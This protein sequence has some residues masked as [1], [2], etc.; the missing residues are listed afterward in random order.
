MS[1][2]DDYEQE[3]SFLSAGNNGAS[4]KAWER[5]F[6]IPQED[7]QEQEESYVPAMVLEVETPVLY[8]TSK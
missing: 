5:E 2:V 4:L 7:E 8:S 3:L 6:V 1:C